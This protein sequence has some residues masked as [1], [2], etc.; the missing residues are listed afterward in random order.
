MLRN[1]G[2]CGRGGRPSATNLGL[3]AARGEFLISVDADCTFDRHLIREAIAPFVDPRVGAVAGNIHVRDPHEGLLTRLQAFEYALSIDVRKRWTTLAGCTLQASGALGAF[4]T[5]LLREIGGWDPELAE[6]TDVS[7]RV[8]KAGYECVF[9]PGAVA[10]TDVPARLDV[11]IRQRTRWDRGGFRNYF[12]KHER[13]LR[14]GSAGPSFTLEMWT[15]FLV[16]VV[17]TAVY[18]VYLACMLVIAPHMLV[19]MLMLAT[20]VSCWLSLICLFAATRVAER[21]EHPA[22]LLWVAILTPFYKSLLRWV[23]FRALVLEVLRLRYED[24]FL[25]RTVWREAPRR[26][27]AAAARERESSGVDAFTPPRSS[28]GAAACVPRSPHPAARR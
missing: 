14:P 9:A 4:R 13:L 15:E 3:A 26:W 2:V 11:L 20:F 5:A 10:F 24:P 21:L 22:R 17:A 12:V 18:P 16:N 1:D 25:P 19:L 23:R 7:L 28:T 27:G 6:D 8:R